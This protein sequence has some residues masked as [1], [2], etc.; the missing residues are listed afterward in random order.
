MTPL[1]N[2]WMRLPAEL[3]SRN[4]WCVAGPDKAPYGVGQG[5]KLYPAKVTNPDTW[6]SF[7][8]ACQAAMFYGA[9]IGFVLSPNDP[10]TVIDMDVKDHE[11]V[12]KNGVPLPPDK[13]TT[14]EDLNR[15]WSIAQT[16]QSYTEKSRSGKGLHVWLY[17]DVG[18]GRRRDGVEVYSRDRFM[19][20]TGNV[21]LDRPIV[22]HPA[23]LAGMVSQMTSVAS[24]SIAL[25]EV[26]EEISDRE[27]IE[28]AST[29]G[30]ADKFN[31]LC[32]LTSDNYHEAGYP[33]QSEADL[34]LMSIFT[35]Y[36]RSNEQCRRLFRLTGLGQREK[37]QK[38]DVYLNRTLGIIRARQERENLV[39]AH[40]QAI[41]ASFAA[42]IAASVD[43]NN[44]TEEPSNLDYHAESEEIDGI[45]R[46]DLTF[47]NEAAWA[48][49][50]FVRSIDLSKTTS[51]GP[52]IND[53]GSGAGG[54][55]GGTGS[56]GEQASKASKGLAWPPGFMGEIAQFI[57]HSSP[58]PVKEVAIVAAMGLM[59]G[60]C[61]RA[62]SIPQSGLNMYAI[63]IARSAVGK[64]A[65]HSGISLLLNAT[66]E[67]YPG[68]HK[69][70]DFTEFVSGPAL[71]KAVAANPCFVNVAGE[72][73]RKIKRMSNDSDTA[74][75]SLRTVMTNLYQKS[76][77][78]SMVG[79]LSYSDKDSNVTSVSGVAF[80]LIGETTPG[81][82]M[83]SLTNSM[84]EDGFL[85]RFCMV[86][87]DGERAPLNRNPITTPSKEL[88][89]FLGE[90][91]IQASTLN[92]RKASQE[93]A[94]DGEAMFV[95]D[96]FNEYCDS[97]I[98]S[99]NEEP[100]RQVWNR[101]HLKVLRLAALIAIGDKNGGPV[102]PVV[103]GE[104]I[105][106]ARELI[107][108][109]IEK[110]LSR[111][112]GGEVGVDDLSRERKMISVLAEYMVKPAPKC[113]NV[114]NKM[115]KEGYV[116]M[117]YLTAR[118]AGV[119][120]FSKHPQGSSR[121]IANTCRDLVEAGYLIE[122]QQTKSI[123]K[124][125]YHGKLF[126]ILTLPDDAINY[127][128]RGMKYQTN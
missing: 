16:F 116:P 8:V 45:D 113:Y 40:A 82:L 61:G 9:G 103:R 70:V 18:A 34:A 72:F 127:A 117:R 90:I 24:S 19:I 27:L 81:T 112:H 35:F 1:V 69:Y 77:T 75:Q 89:T 20:C 123:E 43:I 52:T 49:W 42:Q 3:R 44:H 76:S 21:V 37:A 2:D 93:V 6:S 105:H 22:A 55:S 83:E 91:V 84:M 48:A 10:F 25:V 98:N 122:M 106:W 74:M 38:N 102:N 109:D 66:R 32:K 108:T 118:L 68:I 86:E 94:F 126:R 31:A 125:G 92:S 62:Y 60:I 59:A 14:Q 64:E 88:V 7:E 58:R 87:Y 51:V 128:K 15:Y 119:T 5:G 29:A 79:G 13:W 33:S 47:S 28:I 17:G 11:S 96:K 97:M 41:G 65:M 124:F 101:A 57:F 50:N 104:H 120:C 12:D 100:I 121:S 80:S 39:S 63:L 99:T 46:E 23:M 4:Q 95:A 73:G 53:G 26:E 114:D 107:L 115:R 36:S 30:N 111:L 71:Q 110:F 85:S 67:T 54:G 78:S 56:D